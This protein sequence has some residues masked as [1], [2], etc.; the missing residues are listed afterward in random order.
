[1]VFCPQF[2]HSPKPCMLLSSV[3]AICPAHSAKASFFVSRCK[4]MKFER[5]LSADRTARWKQRYFLGGK[6][7][8]SEESIIL[9]RFLWKW[10]GFSYVEISDSASIRLFLL[11]YDIKWIL[12]CIVCWAGYIHT[13]P[14]LTFKRRIKSRLPFAGIIRSSPYS[15]RFQD[16]G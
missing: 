4:G 13:L 5:H 8:K 14:R 1:M 2:P 15:P 10:S 12:L 11:A 3:R 7:E 9:I 16:K 6:Y